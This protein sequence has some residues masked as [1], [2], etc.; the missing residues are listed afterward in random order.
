MAETLANDSLAHAGTWRRE[1]LR[2]GLITVLSAAF[3]LATNYLR[4]HT[5]NRTVPLF[6]AG[7]GAWPDK[8][9]RITIARL[10]NIQD[11]RKLVILLDVR[12]E[13]LF[14]TAHPAG[15]VNTPAHDFMDYYAEIAPYLPM[16]DKIVI[17]CNSENCPLG[18]RVAH[19][20]TDIKCKNVF[21]LDGGWAA[22]QQ[23]GLP[24][25]G[26]VQ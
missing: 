12:S 10:K 11:E 6:T 5:G 13:E 9:D 22:Y 15:A 3:A 1:L 2:A 20:L 14:K 23:A 16:A 4:D 21:V 26:G 8:A 7:P 25:K 24:I 18:D 19:I 17:I